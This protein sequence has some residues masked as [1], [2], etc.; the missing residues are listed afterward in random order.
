MS[1]PEPV[2][3]PRV[4][5]PVALAFCV[6]GFFALVIAGLG[7]ASLATDTDVISAPGI[8]QSPGAIGMAAAVA[9]FAGVLWWVIRLGHPAFGSVVLVVAATYLAYVVVTG[10]AVAV[11][12]ADLASGLSVA[13]RLA[14]GWQG[15][16]VAAASLV[17]GWAGIALVRTRARRP[18]WPWERADRD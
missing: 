5:P 3:G 18:R 16:I 1:V 9:G 2:G 13:G 15:A 12:A 14:I 8:G 6:I 17:A 11:A 4:R 10:V 7:L